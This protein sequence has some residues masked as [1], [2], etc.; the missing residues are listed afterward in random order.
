MQRGHEW[1]SKTYAACTVA[2]VHQ[3][4]TL[5]VQVTCH[6]GMTKVSDICG[7]SQ[8]KSEDS[9]GKTLHLLYEECRGVGIAGS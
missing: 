9:G 1:A 7:V 6:C 8:A 5:T 2:A 4:I 3:Y